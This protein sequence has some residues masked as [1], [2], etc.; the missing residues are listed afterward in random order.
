MPV[1]I[2]GVLLVISPAPPRPPQ[3]IFSE[4]SLRTSDS[5]M[6]WLA[7]LHAPGRTAEPFMPPAA[8]LLGTKGGPNHSPPPPDGTRH[9]SR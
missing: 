8:K 6:R 7:L 9:A 4:E 5:L 1:V 3:G 2:A